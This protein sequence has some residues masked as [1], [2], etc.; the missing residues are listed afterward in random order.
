ME[1]VMFCCC[2]YL[3]VF[4]PLIS[5]IVRSSLVDGL[6]A[7]LDSLSLVCAYCAVRMSPASV[8]TC[9]P[10]NTPGNGSVLRAPVSF[11]SGDR[12]GDGPET[13]LGSRRHYF[14]HVAESTQV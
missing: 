14:V 1:A 3:C 10:V 11:S 2:V 9:C 13:Q 8:N 6:T 12:D 4:H 7:K 5:C